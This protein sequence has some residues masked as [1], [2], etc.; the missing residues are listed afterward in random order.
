MPELF[1]FKIRGFVRH[2]FYFC[3]I[4]VPLLV[5]GCT[6]ARLDE[7][8]WQDQRLSAVWPQSPEIARI[9]IQQVIRGPQDVIDASSSES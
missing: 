2:C 6:S 3:L 4:I 8:A 7:A 1:V 5:S 9:K